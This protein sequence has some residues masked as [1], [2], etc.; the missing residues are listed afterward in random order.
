MVQQQTNLITWLLSTIL[1]ACGGNSDGRAMP[2]C[3]H[4][5]SES[6]EKY[7]Q[8]LFQ[9]DAIVAQFAACQAAGI[10]AGRFFVNE[11]VNRKHEMLNFRLG[12]F[13]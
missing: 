8:Y 9:P 3:F 10:S 4:R 2:G 1:E 5:L 12:P 11:T 6:D 13:L 7:I